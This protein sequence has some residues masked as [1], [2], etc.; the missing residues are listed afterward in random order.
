MTQ[1]Q[2][3]A[4]DVHHCLRTVGVESL[5]RLDVLS[6]L[7]RHRTT[8]LP[9]ERLARLLGYRIELVVAA[10]ESLAA[11][12]LLQWVI[13]SPDASSCRLMLQPWQSQSDALERLLALGEH[14]S[15]RLLLS[16]HLW[17]GECAG[18]FLDEAEEV[19]DKIIRFYGPTSETVQ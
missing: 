19:L 18:Q 2:V 16:Q 8:L 10:L 9:P 15:G 13:K 1:E 5:C 4:A 6:F 14:R 3:A 7:Y 12:R 17:Q 11:L